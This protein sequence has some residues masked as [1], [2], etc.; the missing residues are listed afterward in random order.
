M[1]GADRAAI[2]NG[3][4]IGRDDVEKAQI[5]LPEGLQFVDFP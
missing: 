4:Q 2:S 3:W 1:H 5:R